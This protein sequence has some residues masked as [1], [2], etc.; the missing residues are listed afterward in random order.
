MVKNIL[1]L[2]CG[3]NLEKFKR[4]CTV[5]EQKM[6]FY[7]TSL[8]VSYVL[9]DSEPVDPYLVDGENVPT[10]EQI[11]ES[12][13]KKYK[14]QVACSKKFIVGKFLNFKMNDAK[15]VVKQV[16]ELQIIVHEMEVEGMGV[17]SNFL[18]GSINEK[19]PQSWKKFKL[20]LKHLTDDMSF[21]Q[22]VLKI[23]VEKDIIDVE[24]FAS[25]VEFATFS[26]VSCI[27]FGLGGSISPE[28]FLSSVL[29]WLVIIV[30]V[31][32]VGV[33]VVVV[34]IVAVVV[35]VESWAKE[36]HQDRAS[37]VKVPV[38]NFNLA[39]FGYAV[40]NK[41]SCGSLSH[42]CGAKDVDILLDGILSP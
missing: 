1:K 16:E 30:A 31:V 14:T 4:F 22:L 21:K 24:K 38:A 42:G 36:F 27:I 12:L 6:L 35:V 33:T 10:E 39:V 3:T 18:V 13:E 20:Y 32:G 26:V 40:R 11:W 23:H 5:R 41:S 8:H 34:I 25:V 37:S 29:L 9:I 2:S 17:N 15:P 7:L 19:L 28:G